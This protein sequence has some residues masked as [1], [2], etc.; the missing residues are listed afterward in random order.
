M[1]KASIFDQLLSLRTYRIGEAYILDRET[2]I[3]DSN[4]KEKAKT[5]TNDI[6]LAQI[7]SYT[8]LEARTQ[9]FPQSQTH[10]EVYT[11]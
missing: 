3:H 5:K 8:Y 7:F 4:K 6:I 10:C 11:I 2:H 9:N 1:M